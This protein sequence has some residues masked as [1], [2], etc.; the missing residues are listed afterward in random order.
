MKVLG[1]IDEDLVNYKV[2]SM[3]IEMPKCDFKCD[4][5]CGHQICQNSTL[6]TAP[7][8]QVIMSNIIQRYQKND[9][10][11]AIVFQGLEPFDS[12]DDL[13]LFCI[14]F[15]LQSIDP[16]V[17]Y[18][19]YNKEEIIDKVEILEKWVGNFIIKYGRYIPDQKPHLDPLLEVELA[20]DNQY[21]VYYD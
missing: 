21:A 12:W 13:F 4:R 19:G 11:S 6:A 5:E 15:R 3:I 16:I 9:I 10:T 17:I 14:L 1:I 18:T 7:Q 8:Q 2:P 20:S